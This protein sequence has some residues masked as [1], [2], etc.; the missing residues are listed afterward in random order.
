VVVS[1]SGPAVLFIRRR[2]RAGDPWS[3]QMALPGGFQ[4]LPG[5]PALETALRETREE[6]GL[7]LSGSRV[8]G[9]L[10]ELHP[11][12]ALLPPIVVTPWVFVVPAQADVAPGAEAETA[13]WIAIQD[14]FAPENRTVITVPFPTAPREFPAIRIG[15]HLVWGLT[16]RIVAQIEDLVGGD[17]SSAAERSP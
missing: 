9:A 10:D 11:R 1:E 7:D 4:R 13:V 17:G 14:L 5:E 3:G 8:V 15:P 6:T 2:E 16:E 12:T